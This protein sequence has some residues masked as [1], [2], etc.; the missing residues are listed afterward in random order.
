MSDPFDA[1]ELWFAH[2]LAAVPVPASLERAAVRPAPATGRR[3]RRYRTLVLAGALALCV[4]VLGGLILGLTRATDRSGAPATG[5]A[6]APSPRVQPGLSGDDVHQNVVLYG[7][8]GPGGALLS[9]TWIWD[10]HS[11]SE[12]HPLHN[13]GPRRAAA[14]SADPGAGGV[15]LLGGVGTQGETLGDSWEWDGTDWRELSVAAPPGPRAGALFVQDPVNFHVMLFG[16]RDGRGARGTTWFWDGANWAE[17]HPVDEPPDCAG[18]TMAYDDAF[19]RVVLTTGR[20]C[21]AP[22]VAG[23]TWT[24]DGHDWSRLSPPASPLPADGATLAYHD[25]SQMLVLAVPPVAHGCALV[26]WTWDTTTWT[27]HRDAGAPLGPA[28]AVRDPASRRPLLVSASGQT[29]SW[30]GNDWTVV[31]GPADA[32]SSCPTP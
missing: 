1:D 29:W 32:P 11:W 9:D 18:S 28:V 5:S 8:R 4:G 6:T 31:A 14:M 27:V 17:Q 12:R 15:V 16:G 13:P 22:G 19:R 24:W 21:T 26:T 10:G 23:S 25:A 2:L 3:P 20:G 30:D 7:G